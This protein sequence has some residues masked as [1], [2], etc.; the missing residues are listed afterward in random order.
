MI[1]LN[2]TGLTGALWSCK[3]IYFTETLSSVT[4]SNSDFE[5]QIPSQESGLPKFMMKLSQQFYNLINHGKHQVNI[6][7]KITIIGLKFYSF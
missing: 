6:D 2:Y 5:F 4:Y 3:V 7:N 1:I